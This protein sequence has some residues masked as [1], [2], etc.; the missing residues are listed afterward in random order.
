[1]PPNKAFL[2]PIADETLWRPQHESL[3]FLLPFSGSLYDRR[4]CLKMN[5]TFDDSMLWAARC[6]RLSSYRNLI[7][8]IVDGKSLE[9]VKQAEELG[10]R[11]AE[12]KLLFYAWL[13]LSRRFWPGWDRKHGEH[14]VA[15]HVQRQALGH[16][17]LSFVILVVDPNV[18][19]GCQQPVKRS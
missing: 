1:M 3:N 18:K 16:V 13:S 8:G 10:W 2:M 17:H 19:H 5:S 11:T 12:N 4:E 6:P 9:M 15:R 14:A 7:L